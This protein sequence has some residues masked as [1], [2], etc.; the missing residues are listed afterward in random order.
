M[1]IW[2]AVG[3]CFVAFAARA[4]GAPQ[5]YAGAWVWD[6]AAYEAPEDM[7]EMHH[8]TAETMLITHDDGRRY[9][10]RIE[11]V[12]DDGQRRVLQ[13][14]FAEDGNFHMQGSAPDGFSVSISLLQDGARHVVSRA[15]GDLHDMRCMV[16]GDAMTL[17]C[18]GEHRMADGRKGAVVCVYHR[19][20]HMTPVS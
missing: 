6:R 8:M 15:G 10:G 12:F 3:W 11:Q 2:L 17:T 13:E 9:S 1:R 7:P 14:N 4:Q 19:D 18:A 20:E 16:S 5:P